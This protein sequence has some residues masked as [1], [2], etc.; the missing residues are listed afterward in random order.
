MDGVFQTSYVKQVL[1]VMEVDHPL[2]ILNSFRSLINKSRVDDDNP[3]ILYVNREAV[4][5]HPFVINHYKDT[6]R[7]VFLLTL[8]QRQC[9]QY[10][11]RTYNSVYIKLRE[12]N[13]SPMILL[14]SDYL[15]DNGWITIPDMFMTTTYRFENGFTYK[16]ITIQNKSYDW[17]IY[18]ILHTKVPYVPK[19]I[20][21]DLNVVTNRNCQ[22]E[23]RMLQIAPN[24]P[25]KPISFETFKSSCFPIKF[26]SD[27][28][29][30]HLRMRDENDKPLMCV[31]NQLPSIFTFLISDGSG[32]TSM[33]MNPF[34]SK[35]LFLKAKASEFG[36]EGDVRMDLRGEDLNA[37]IKSYITLNSITLPS[38]NFAAFPRFAKDFQLKMLRSVIAEDKKS[39]R[40]EQWSIDFN[41][42]LTSLEDV[43]KR[44]VTECE[45]NGCPLT[46]LQVAKAEENKPMHLKWAFSEQLSMYGNRSIMEYLGLLEKDA[47]SM[48]FNQDGLHF[49][50]C[51]KDAVFETF[52]KITYFHP[53][54]MRLDCEALKPYAWGSELSKTL[55]FIDVSSSS[56]HYTTR[57]FESSPREIMR[58]NYKF[59]IFKL[60]NEQ[61]YPITFQ[62][63]DDDA[64]IFFHFTVQQDE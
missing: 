52:P 33:T 37:E 26:D 19:L 57:S 25:Y 59:L 4:K 17:N 42:E 63:S 54:I 34:K 23:T 20:N 6:T 14:I 49:Y 44:I 24:S 39:F 61:G 64:W 7:L 18:M 41:V 43:V 11:W 50:T 8:L 45:K 15:L 58:G 5:Y 1:P 10:D 28:N 47:C 51:L 9:V 13:G 62:P 31:D 35:H 16:G 21:L 55:R 32:R 29:Y 30:F 12:E 53:K 46:S 3:G 56:E 27:L 2:F 48:K 22:H 36:E 38:S 40:K 60:L